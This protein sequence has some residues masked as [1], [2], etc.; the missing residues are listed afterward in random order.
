MN[1]EE[2]KSI[3]RFTTVTFTDS[4]TSSPILIISVSLKLSV[5]IAHASLV[6]LHRSRLY[7]ARSNKRIYQ[8]GYFLCHRDLLPRSRYD[9]NISGESFFGSLICNYLF[10]PTILLFSFFG[11]PQL[12]FVSFNIHYVNK[13]AKIRILNFIYN[14]DAFTSKLLYKGF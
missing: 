9:K 3:V 5:P 10:A 2:H 6:H 11:L 7:P 1:Y 13:L 14:C 12:N 4:K 8:D